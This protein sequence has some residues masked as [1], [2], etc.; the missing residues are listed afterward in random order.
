MQR[1]DMEIYHNPSLVTTSLM[2]TTTD[3]GIPP[4]GTHGAVVSGPLWTPIAADA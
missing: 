1:R 2:R 3:L 4:L